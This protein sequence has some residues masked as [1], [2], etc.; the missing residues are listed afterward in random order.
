MKVKI[1]DHGFVFQVETE[2]EKD[3]CGKLLDQG[4]ELIAIARHSTEDLRRF[5]LLH[6]DRRLTVKL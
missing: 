6:V 4:C 1:H 2:N 3:M 5:M